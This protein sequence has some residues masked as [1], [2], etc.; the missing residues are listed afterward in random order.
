MEQTGG[1]LTRL[2]SL[3]KNAA[4]DAASR[5]LACLLG[6]AI[7][8][9][10]GYRVEFQ[11]WH[12]IEREY[13]PAGIRLA[14]C[15]GPLVVS[16]DTQ[17]TLFTLEGM[18]RARS[19]EQITEE[20]REAYLDWLRTQGHRSERPLRGQLVREQSMQHLRAPGNTCLAALRRG[21]EGTVERPIND[22]KGCGGVMRTA[23]LGLLPNSVS[24]TEVF[25]L[26]VE[27]AALTH[28]HPDGYLPAGA[29][30]MLTRDALNA[31]PWDASIA[32]VL[33][34]VRSWPESGGTA[35]AIEAAVQAASDGVASRE[36]VS[37]LGEGWVGEEA[38]AIGLYAA[39]VAR[40]FAQCI[41][42]AANHDGDSDS[43]A[44]IAG[45]LWGARYGLAVI[46]AEAVEQLDVI[47][48]LLGVWERWDGRGR[49][50]RQ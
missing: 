2:K 17:M 20:I 29:M 8:D 28:G 3:L 30:A 33:G 34:L 6:G 31:M 44:S 36:R 1:H 13:G 4:D 25:R 19:L 12:E 43:T 47:E 9:A 42:L 14:A 7:G 40:T 16:D 37:T 49:S 21:G 18:A 10:L 24:D 41:E 23:P 32:K 11:R 50:A 22:S 39:I 46:P 35:A 26:G 5:R 48:A 38:L 15:D 27:T 45:Q